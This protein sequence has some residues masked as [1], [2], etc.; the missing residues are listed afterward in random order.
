METKLYNLP[1][2]VAKLRNISGSLDLFVSFDGEIAETQIRIDVATEKT[3]IS[4]ELSE[5]QIFAILPDFG[6]ASDIDISIMGLEEKKLTGKL[7]FSDSGE[8][9]PSTLTY[10]EGLESRGSFDICAVKSGNQ[11]FQAKS[12]SINIG[13][14]TKSLFQAIENA[15][16]SSYTNAS[17]YK[18]QS[19]TST[20]VWAKSTTPRFYQYQFDQYYSYSTTSA[21]A[22]SWCN[23]YNYSHIINEAGFPVFEYCQYIKGSNAGTLVEQNV[24]GYYYNFSSFGN[25]R[26][27]STTVDI[28]ITIKKNTSTATQHSNSW[29]FV[30]FKQPTGYTHE[31][32]V[33]FLGTG[34]GLQMLAYYTYFQPGSTTPTYAGLTSSDVVATGTLQSDGSIKFTGTIKITLSIPSNGHLTAVIENTSTSTTKTYSNI[35]DSSVNTSYTVRWFN[36]VSL[37]PQKATASL[38]DM[39][40]CASMA[41]VKLKNTQLYSSATATSGSSF[42]P[43]GSLSQYAFLY[44]TDCADYSTSGTGTNTV[45][46]INIFYD[47]GI[48]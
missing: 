10:I 32:G 6:S 17:V 46:T 47:R 27:I 38:C 35:A 8:M 9:P 19:G 22:E 24:G 26:K 40:N 30:G 11:L 20:L 28:N 15:R 41:N 31:A 14:S 5:E 25:Y 43:A 37:V 13:S 18:I 34:T 7:H 42:A 16:D 2:R 48:T 4:C 23:N 44:N 39:R 21:A 29:I 12:G 45:E 36:G 3:S 1:I 33:R